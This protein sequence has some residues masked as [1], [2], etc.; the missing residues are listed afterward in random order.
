MINKKKC[1][2]CMVF[3]LFDVFG[4]YSAVYLT[5]YLRILLNPL[6]TLNFSIE[7]ISDYFINPFI[8]IIIWVIVS[9]QSGLYDLKNIGSFKN[10]IKTLNASF[11]T[12]VFLITISFILKKE[13]ISRSLIIL[14]IFFNIISVSF[15]RFLGCKV[16]SWFKEKGVWGER[17]AI[18]GE[19]IHVTEIAHLLRKRGRLGTIFSGHITL[20]SKKLNLPQNFDSE[21]VLGS[22]DDVES[23]VRKHNINRVIFVDKSLSEEK[24]FPLIEFCEKLNVTFEILPD[25]YNLTASKINDEIEGIPLIQLRGFHLPRSVLLVKRTLETTISLILCI[26]LLPFLILV[27]VLIKLESKGSMIFRQKRYGKNGMIFTFY[28]FRSMAED[29]YVKRTDLKEY[30]EKGDF[31]FKIKDDPRITKVGRFIRRYSLDELPQLFNILK[32]EMSLVGPRPLPVEDLIDIEKSKYKS[33]FKYRSQLPPG[34][35]G[36]WQV[37]G[38]SESEFED[39]VKDDLYYIQNW[40]LSMDIMIILKTFY[41]V[42][43]GY[44]AY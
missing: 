44:G 43:R 8:V 25:L 30:N 28:K 33:W 16:L 37:S 27:P 32:G 29:A 15:F 38:R 41:V 34:L 35:T 20:N 6:F 42:I 21:L 19:N 40:T 24:L 36:L 9:T 23:I 5:Y 10:W 31:I 7:N 17:V 1:I 39:L 4:V 3:I 18:I 12:L 22:I 2:S 26:L 14:F 11:I 13:E